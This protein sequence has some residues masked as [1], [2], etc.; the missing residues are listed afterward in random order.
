LKLH[1]Y[2]NLD[3]VEKIVEIF[4][5]VRE[6]SKS[7]FNFKRT[8]T[9]LED[10]ITTPNINSISTFSPKMTKAIRSTSYANIIQKTNSKVRE[11]LDDSKSSIKSEEV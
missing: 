8:N 9:N 4:E 2:Y 5:L 1:T 7:T 6:G 10:L 11:Q 3:L